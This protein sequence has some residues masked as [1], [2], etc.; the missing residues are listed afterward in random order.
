MD[1]KSPPSNS[2][3]RVEVEQDGR[4]GRSAP[5]KSLMKENIVLF[6][7][8]AGVVLGFAIG[9]GVRELNPTADA[10]MWIGQWS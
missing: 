3:V 2:M 9:F 8:L 10:L 4:T 7:T 1:T 5:C 6:L